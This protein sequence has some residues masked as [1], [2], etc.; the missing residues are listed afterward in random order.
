MSVGARPAQR[1]RLRERLATALL[2]IVS[3]AFVLGLL[4]VAAR[5]ARGGGGGKEGRETD[6]YHQ[7]DPLLGWA[8]KP[9]ARVAYRRREYAVEVAINSKG[10]RDPERGYDAPPG[11]L[12]ILALGDSFLEGYTVPLEQ[13]VTQRLERSLR[14]AGA[15]A[16]VL[17][18]G[19]A[20]YSTDQEYLFYQSEGLRYGP[21]VVLV[22]FYY[23]DIVY[24]DRQDYFGL[25]KPIF[26]Q[27]PDGLHLHRY[28]VREP[29]PAAK[30]PPRP[31]DEAQHSGSALYE[32]VRDR[33]WYGAPKAYDALA[34]LGF[35]P[36][37][38][39][40]G[41]R[42]ELRVY[43]KARIAEIDD[44][45]SKTGAILGAFA[46]EATSRGQH[47]LVIYVPSRMEVDDRSWQLSQSLYGMD[48]S[49]WDRGLVARRLEQVGREQDFP[50]LDLTGALR[51]ADRGW[52]GRPYFIYDGHWSALGHDTAARE[53]EAAFLARGWVPGRTD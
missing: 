43:Q 3:L 48:E 27:R 45:W 33:M 44:A 15:P 35:W 16:E 52:R 17:N 49:G 12:R 4:E 10:L 39:R 42:L 53:I 8:K 34:R 7:Y 26:E 38:P 51:K 11:T 23:N 40:L 46:R 21:R 22:F 47:L 14:A 9:G 5:I 20:A 31:E 2:A 30:R 29:P 24:N 36:P 19:T 1:S 32:W 6:V 37:L 25:P 41:Q 18:A 28:P 13:T 50:V